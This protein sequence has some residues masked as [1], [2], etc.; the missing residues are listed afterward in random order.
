M[1]NHLSLIDIIWLLV[2]LTGQALFSM[3]FLLQWIATER[4]RK[5]V[6][7]VAFWYYSIAG[8]IV[9]FAY[10]AY[11][12]DP[13]FMLGQ[14]FGVV[15]YARNLYFIYKERQETRVTA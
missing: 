4:E 8:S 2:G 7:P 14:T 11:K 1:F 3:R 12:Q 5:S 6:V 13:V 15:I 9:L 10:A